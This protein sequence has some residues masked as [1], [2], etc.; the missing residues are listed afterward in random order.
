M[1]LQASIR[2]FLISLRPTSASPFLNEISPMGRAGLDDVVT[3]RFIMLEPPIRGSKWQ[4]LSNGCATKKT[5]QVWGW[6]L[7]LC[8][9][10]FSKLSV[11]FH[12]ISVLSLIF[13]IKTRWKSL[14]SIHFAQVSSQNITFSVDF[15]SSSKIFGWL[16]K[17]GRINLY[18]HTW[19]VLLRIMIISPEVIFQVQINSYPKILKQL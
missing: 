1:G 2:L 18:L 16:C 9:S 6:T 4:P 13:S 8:D 7:V 14:K 3:I 11:D 15:F 19:L 12:N 5:N 17:S 10:D